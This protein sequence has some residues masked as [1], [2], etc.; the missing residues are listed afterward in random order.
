MKTALNFLRY[1]PSAIGRLGFDVGR[2]FFIGWMDL[3]VNL[4]GWIIIVFTAYGIYRVF[5]K[6]FL[7]MLLH[8]LGL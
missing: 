6:H 2:F 5:I 8:W 3:M 7:D 4:V 1:A